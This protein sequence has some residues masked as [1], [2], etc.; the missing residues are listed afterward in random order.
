MDTAGV[1]DADRGCSEAS[2]AI[3]ETDTETA[4]TETPAK[5]ETPA[6]A[7]VRVKE[8]PG[9]EI[10]ASVDVSH[11]RGVWLFWRGAARRVYGCLNVYRVVGVSTLR[12]IAAPPLE[13][14]LLS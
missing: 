3:T 13:Y 7:A 2:D 6:P 9:D 5:D 4:P 12:I 8:E 10:K 14:S 11:W 1:A